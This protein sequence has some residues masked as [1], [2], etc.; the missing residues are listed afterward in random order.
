MICRKKAQFGIIYK[1]VSLSGKVYIGQTIQ[2]LNARKWYH[3]RIAHDKSKTL[4]NTKFSRAIRK[5]GV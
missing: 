3:F 4:Y 2:K 1:A 5:Y